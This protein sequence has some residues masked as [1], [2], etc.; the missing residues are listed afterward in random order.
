MQI[1]SLN[2]QAR[3]QACASGRMSAFLSYDGIGGIQGC[4][5]G[6]IIGITGITGIMRGWRNEIAR[7]S[8]DHVTAQALQQK[9]TPLQ[10]SPAKLPINN[11]RATDR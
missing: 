5:G 7:G 9:N 3:E 1:F 4:A 10:I 11:M 8:A 2:A 6:R